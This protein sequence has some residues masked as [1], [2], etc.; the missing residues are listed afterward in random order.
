VA[1]ALG[2]D[3]LSD[4]DLLL[5][6]F[7]AEVRQRVKEATPLWYYMLCEADASPQDGRRLGPVAGRI[8]AEVLVGLLVSDRESYIH[9]SPAWKPHIGPTPGDFT[10]RDLVLIGQGTI[11]PGSA[12]GHPDD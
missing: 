1:R 3:V 8:V 7:K 10:M 11:K 9:K 4:D 12:T 6:L 2:C 5:P